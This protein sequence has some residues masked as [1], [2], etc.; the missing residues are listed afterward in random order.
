[1]KFFGTL[2]SVMLTLGLAALA[3]WMLDLGD[4]VRASLAAGHLL[5]WVM[6]TLCLLWLGVILKVPWDLY[7]Q[8]QAVTF[9]LQRSQERGVQIVAGREQYLR[10]LRSRLGW[11]AVGAHVASAA[12]IALITYFTGGAVGYYFAAFYLIATF[13][14]PAAAGYVYLSGKLSAIAEEVR[15]PRE[16]IVELRRR[17][18]AQNQNGKE[19]WERVLAL[20]TSLSNERAERAGETRE[21][22]QNVHNIGREFESTISRLTDNQE[23]IKG[24]QAFVRLVAQSAN[25]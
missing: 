6:G 8:A 12:L 5:D 21:L 7:F 11:L 10:R 25:S 14:R 20:E 16:D 19:L 9:E 3:I 22:R 17:F 24:I 18:D 1:M 2:F 4:V 15:Y 23:I 13:F